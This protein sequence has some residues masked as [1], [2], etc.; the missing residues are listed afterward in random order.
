MMRHRDR[1]TVTVPVHL[2]PD[3][4]RA[5]EAADPGEGFVLRLSATLPD[6][7]AEHGRPAVTRQAKD[8]RFLRRRDSWRQRTATQLALHLLTGMG[9]VFTEGAGARNRI[10]T[11]PECVLEGEWALCIRCVRTS[12]PF[13]WIGHVLIGA[14]VAA[15]FTLFVA[16][17]QG[18]R[19]VALG[20]AIFF[21]AGCRVRWWSLPWLMSG[22]APS[23][24]SMR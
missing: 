19:P 1:R 20:I 21:P 5:E 9:R 3:I 7:C 8:I 14:G 10:C 22:R 16:V 23:S 24:T 11:G 2:R 4:E 12:L 18:L 15:L 17:Q 13:R 6:L